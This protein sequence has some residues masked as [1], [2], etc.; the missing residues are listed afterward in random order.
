MKGDRQ[1][2]VTH[3]QPQIGDMVFK[4]AKFVLVCK[5]CSES[6]VISH[7]PDSGIPKYK[8]PKCDRER[9]P[10][11]KNPT[12]IWLQYEQEYRYRVLRVI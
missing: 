5:L 7:I 2:L 4:S 3:E 6:V 1:L 9:K 11:L 12:A 8:C 10:T